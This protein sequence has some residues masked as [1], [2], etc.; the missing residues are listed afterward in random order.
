MIEITSAPPYLTVQ[1]L[2]RPGYRAQGVPAGGA[3]DPTALSIANVLAGNAP[4]TGALEW[5]LGGG[6]FVWIARARSPWRVLV[7]AAPLL[8]VASA[9]FFGC[10]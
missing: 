4:S 3:M 10:G 5:A 9:L 8:V 6:R 2:G 1:D 7:L